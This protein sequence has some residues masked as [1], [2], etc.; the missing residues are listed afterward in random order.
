MV[1]MRKLL[2]A[3]AE[4]SHL[5]ATTGDHYTLTQAVKMEHTAMVELPL[6]IAP[7][8]LPRMAAG[9]LRPA[10]AGLPDPRLNGEAGA[11][12]A[13]GRSGLLGALVAVLAVEADLVGR[14]GAGEGRGGEEDENNNGPG[15]RF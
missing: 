12:G 5:A 2:N 8:F 3:G 1:M 10:E 9:H 15:S 7:G 6:D 14:G 13:S 11:L 4:L